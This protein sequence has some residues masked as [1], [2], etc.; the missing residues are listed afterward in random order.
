[1]SSPIVHV[2]VFHS[3]K[4]SFEIKTRLPLG[5]SK[6]NTSLAIELIRII[7]LFISQSKWTT[8]AEDPLPTPTL[9]SFVV[10]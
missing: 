5:A 2:E 10:E 6:Y 4:L 8:V 1:M 9:H 3:G 7:L